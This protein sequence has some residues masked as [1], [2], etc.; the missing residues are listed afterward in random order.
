MYVCNFYFLFKSLKCARHFEFQIAR[1]HWLVAH[2]MS[3]CCT[4][5]VLVLFV[6]KIEMATYS[7]NGC[8]YV[9]VRAVR[10]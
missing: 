9:G 3:E 7:V 5:L 1:A 2:C 8:H 4:T 10:L 6:L